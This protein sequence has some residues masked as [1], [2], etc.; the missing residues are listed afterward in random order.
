M[1][2][3]TRSSTSSRPQ[4]LV[5][6][7]HGDRNEALEQGLPW[8]TWAFVLRDLGEGTTRLIVRMRSEFKP[9]LVGLLANKYGLEP[10]HLLMERKMLLGIKHRAEPTPAS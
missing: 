9:T 6:G 7:P 10:V 1:G 4:T 5:L 8:P 2:C 3:G